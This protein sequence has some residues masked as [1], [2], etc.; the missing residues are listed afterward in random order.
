MKRILYCMTGMALLV[1]CAKESVEALQTEAV[2]VPLNITVQTRASGDGNVVHD[3]NSIRIMV[4]KDLSGEPANDLIVLNELY[5]FGYGIEDVG[6]KG[7]YMVSVKPTFE[8]DVNTNDYYVYA[9]LNENGYE[10]PA[11]PDNKVLSTELDKL[12][13]RSQMAALL[14]TPAV[15]PSDGISNAPYCLMSACRQVTF[16]S[17]D[18]PIDVHFGL[19]E[20]DSSNPAPIDRT[21][22]QITVESIQSAASTPTEANMTLLPK[23]FV[24]DVKL[25]NVPKGITWS[26]ADGNTESG[27][28]ELPIGEATA[29]EGSTY[30]Y[31]R[32]WG[33]YVNKDIE[34]IES[35]EQRMTANYYRTAATG[36][37]NWDFYDD[38][39][40]ATPITKY[41]YECTLT[42]PTAPTPVVT[43]PLGFPY[44][45]GDGKKWQYQ[46]KKADGT[47][48]D[49]TVEIKN[50]EN[51]AAAYAAAYADYLANLPNKGDKKNPVFV[52]DEEAEAYNIY[53]PLKKQYDIDLDAY[54]AAVSGAYP[55]AVTGR[56]SIDATW[57]ATNSVADLITD[58]SAIFQKK[59]YY[60]TNKYTITSLGSSHSEEYCTPDRW[61][62]NLGDSYYVPE[63]IQTS[64]ANA[65]CVKVSLAFAAPTI[66]VSGVP[67]AELPEAADATGGTYTYYF[68]HYYNKKSGKNDPQVI[69]KQTYIL[70]TGQLK[71]GG[72][73]KILKSKR[74]NDGSYGDP[75]K[76]DFSVATLFEYDG[77]I[78][79]ADDETIECTAA[80][81]NNS[82]HVYI[83]GESFWRTGTG[84][85]AMTTVDQHQNGATFSWNIPSSDDD[86]TDGI[87]EVKEFLIPV[88]NMQFDGDYSIRR[89]TRYTVKLTVGQN[90]LLGMK[91]IPA[92]APT[93]AGESSDY[94]Y[95]ISAT[96]TAENITDYED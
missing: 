55:A 63:N 21:M 41:T 6:T 76:K 72:D 10:L 80:T 20:K 54:N 62:V 22:A 40:G 36:N 29:Q 77:H 82:Y 12:S 11:S 23:I 34:V 91:V 74:N 93:R 65:T 66:D 2:N 53:W 79:D 86:G 26:E 46:T 50:Y 87:Y 16:T 42:E 71:D 48:Q 69:D 25:V 90:T 19:Y 14:S 35:V 37:S 68:D 39:D 17:K 33:G 15:Y 32:I 75:E 44:L 78:V 59:T 45:S 57:S 31:P 52:T 89:N 85:T 88:N 8:L 43:K 4:F 49:K 38:R 3:I 95:G 83:D 84:L 5:T 30:Y 61:K 70:T 1:S 94:G 13:N 60:S 18:D 73:N 9:V 64:S 28:V 24:L 56:S 81:A 92:S 67:L 47:N 58:L 51:S 27:T 96:V 7:R